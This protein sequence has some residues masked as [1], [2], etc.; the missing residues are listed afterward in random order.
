ME[1]FFADSSLVTLEERLLFKPT[2]VIQSMNTNNNWGVVMP[3]MTS[4]NCWLG[5]GHLVMRYV[6]GFQSLISGSSVPPEIPPVGSQALLQNNKIRNSGVRFINLYFNKSSRWFWR[7]L[8][9]KNHRCTFKGLVNFAEWVSKWHI[10]GSTL[11]QP[12]WYRRK[13]EEEKHW[14]RVLVLF[15]CW[16]S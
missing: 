12:W 2:E 3:F 11:N 13:K 5:V 15:W 6:E 9:F 10:L 14:G 1:L 7:M 4:Y 16:S 8:T